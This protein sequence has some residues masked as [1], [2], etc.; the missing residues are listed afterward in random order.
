M[1][2]TPTPTTIRP[3]NNA[4]E[5]L[6][7]LRV[8]DAHAARWAAMGPAVSATLWTYGGHALLEAHR[9]TSANRTI[10]DA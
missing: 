9:T 7:D 2:A 3:G 1:S 10:L 5:Q 8:P 4:R 6:K